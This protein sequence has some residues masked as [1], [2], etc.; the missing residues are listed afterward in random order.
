VDYPVICNHLHM[1]WL[2]PLNT[3]KSLYLIKLSPEVHFLSIWESKTYYFCVFCNNTNNYFGLLFFQNCFFNLENTHCPRVNKT[4]FRQ[5]SMMKYP[6][7]FQL[8]VKENLKCIMH[9]GTIPFLNSF[10]YY[11][12]LHKTKENVQAKWENLN[13][14]IKDE[15]FWHLWT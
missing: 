9:T 14:F 12:L 2:S 13:I 3:G 7:D 5:V 11:Y 4:C 10:S 6:N 1:G 15:R 8:K